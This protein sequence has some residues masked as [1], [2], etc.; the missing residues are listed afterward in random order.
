VAEDEPDVRVSAH[1]P[2][3]HE[4]VGGAA[5]VQQE[6]G[7][8]RDDPVARRARKLGIDED[9]RSAVFEGTEPRVLAAGAEIH[10]AIVG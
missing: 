1:H 10:A 7:G 4:Q 5:G 8:E 6:I 9:D 2:V 3:A